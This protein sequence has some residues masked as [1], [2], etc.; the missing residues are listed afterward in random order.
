[1]ETRQHTI[2]VLGAGGWGTALAVLL[3]RNGHRVRI[4]CYEP[5]EVDNMRARGE[6]TRFLPGV[7]VPADIELSTE[8]GDLL[9]GVTLI[10]AA[11]PAQHTRQVIQQ[12]ARK[13]PSPCPVINVAK[14]IENK[15][16]KRMSQVLTEELPP[17]FHAGIGTISGPSHA[18]EVGR[19]IPTAV[20]IASPNP[21][22]PPLVQQVF[23]NETFRV[24]S[25]EDLVGVELAGSL[26]NVIALAAGISDGLSFG[27]NTKGALLTRGLAEISRLGLAMGAKAHTF[28]GLAGMGDLITTA[29]S[30]HSRNRFVG[31]KIG[32]GQRLKEV[33]AEM[34]MVAEGVATTES[35]YEL[36]K[37]YGVDMPITQEVYAALF[38]DK[39]A[40]QAVS[41]LMNRPAKPEI[42]W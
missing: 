33:L 2:L 27:D 38:E 17:F 25:S 37:R 5:I 14:G 41:D 3:R 7:P 40:R 11:S 31:E 24:Y 21:R 6:N 39:E 36:G 18:E 19:G 30:R 8:M 34:V 20:V 10:V 13:G 32:R 28:A 15:S 22:T 9:S 12:L 29:M 26:K 23:M 1:M 16:L 4:W 35:A 42:Y